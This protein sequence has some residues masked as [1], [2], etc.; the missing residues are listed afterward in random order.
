LEVLRLSRYE[1]FRMRRRPAFTVLCILSALSILIPAA[2]AA[3]FVNLDF[4]SDGNS[5]AAE[6][7]KAAFGFSASPFNAVSMC[8]GALAFGADFGTGGYRALHMRG[9]SRMAV[10][11]S[12]VVYFLVVLVALLAAGWIL[13][14]LVSNIATLISVGSAYSCSDCIDS[15]AQLGRALPGIAFW[16]LIGAGL[17]FWGRSTTFGVG[18]G[19]GYYFLSSIVQPALS[20]GFI[21]KWDIDIGP[22][23]HWLPDNLVVAFFNADSTHVSYWLSGLGILAYCAVIVT[24][25][26]WLS[27]ARDLTPSR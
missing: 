27:R 23:L 8:I 7:L 4:F 1:W 25:I 26:L 24:F 11:L 15:L 6:F 2:V 22:V 21:W 5:G 9:A 18:V 17:A 19:F 13:S 3:I 10:P 12:K 14:L 16:S 20:L